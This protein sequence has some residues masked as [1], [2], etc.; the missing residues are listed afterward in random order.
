MHN[1]DRLLKYK[2]LP[3]IY[4]YSMEYKNIIIDIPGTND[5]YSYKFEALGFEIVNGIDGYKVKIEMFVKAFFPS[6]IDGF[7]KSI[8]HIVFDKDLDAE[9]FRMEFGLE[10]TDGYL[11][12]AAVFI[13]RNNISTIEMCLN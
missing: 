8:Y 1:N 12:M 4:H 6:L 9:N 2:L 5:G 13:G 7:V 10:T 11:T 3:G